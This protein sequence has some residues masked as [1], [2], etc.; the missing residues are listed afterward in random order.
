METGGTLLSLSPIRP[1]VD[2][3]PYLW[4]F[5]ELREWIGNVIFLQGLGVSAVYLSALS[6]SAFFPK[7]SKNL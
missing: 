1:T 2:P 7:G 3:K 5:K 4:G 6:F